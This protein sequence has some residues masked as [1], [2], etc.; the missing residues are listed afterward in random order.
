MWHATFTQVNQGDSQHLVVGN[1]IDILIPD[2]FL[3]HNLCFKYSNGSCELIL[4]IYV[5]RAFQWYKEFFNPMNFDPWDCSL[6]IWDSIG[7]PTPKVGIHLGVCGFIPSHIPLHSWKCKCDS[8]V[9]LLAW[10]F[11]CFYFSRELKVRV[12]RG[13]N[14]TPILSC[15]QPL[16]KMETNWKVH[17]LNSLKIYWMNP[18]YN[19]EVVL[20]LMA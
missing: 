13:L 4:N 19:C 6:K 2:P 18:K 7:T 16:Y 20:P 10:T 15:G 3:G 17:L 1:Q 5:S 9:A 12:M 8:R 14:Q 11:P